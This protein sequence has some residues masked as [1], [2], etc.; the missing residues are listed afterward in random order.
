MI[1]QSNVYLKFRDVIKAINKN[2]TKRNTQNFYKQEEYTS[3]FAQI[4]CFKDK[5]ILEIMLN[6]WE[7]AIKD[8]IYNCKDFIDGSE[9]YQIERLSLQ[10]MTKIINIGKY[11]INVL[12]M[13]PE[14]ALAFTLGLVYGTF[15]FEPTGLCL[16]LEEIYSILPKNKQT[17]YGYKTFQKRYFIDGTSSEISKILFSNI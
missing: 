12:K 8:E 15:I 1:Q 10:E 9:E 16:T 2:N 14:I 3:T 4:F 7:K 13:K 5:K 11:A 6:K 17:K